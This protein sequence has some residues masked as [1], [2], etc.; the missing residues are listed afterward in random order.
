MRN[1]R[2]YWTKCPQKPTNHES[3]WPQRTIIRKAGLQFG[4]VIRDALCGI[5][6]READLSAPYGN[7]CFFAVITAAIEEYYANLP[8]SEEKEQKKSAKNLKNIRQIPYFNS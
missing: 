1:T 8:V 5:R 2:Q 3:T 6:Q 4:A 7:F